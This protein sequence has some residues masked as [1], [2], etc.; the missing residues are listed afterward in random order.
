[1]SFLQSWAMVLIFL[2]ADRLPK[3]GPTCRGTET[4]QDFKKK[5]KIEQDRE[6]ERRK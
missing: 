3:G 2:S 5:E 4:E 1:M 6:K